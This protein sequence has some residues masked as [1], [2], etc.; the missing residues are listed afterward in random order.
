MIKG[1][2]SLTKIVAAI[3]LALLLGACAVQ[4]DALIKYGIEDQDD[5]LAEFLELGE[6]YEM[7]AK[8][9]AENIDHRKHAEQKLRGLIT[10]LEWY[11]DPGNWYAPEHPKASVIWQSGKPWEPAANALG[12]DS[13][14]LSEPTPRETDG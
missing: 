7:L 1:W 4:Q 6:R 8:L 2:A 14:P 3:V 9:A 12:A 10:A 11:A 13:A 5:Y